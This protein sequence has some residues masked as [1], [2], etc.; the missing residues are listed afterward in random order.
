[1]EWK[2]GVAGQPA[3]AGAMVQETPLHRC[4]ALAVGDVTLDDPKR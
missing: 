3:S 4:F 1:M 2:P